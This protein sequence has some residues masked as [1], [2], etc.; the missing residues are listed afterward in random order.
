VEPVPLFKDDD[1]ARAECQR[2]QVR[3]EEINAIY[4]STSTNMTGPVL[5]SYINVLNCS[6][7]FL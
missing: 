3:S 2:F 7:I 6:T 4:H 5:L 1:A